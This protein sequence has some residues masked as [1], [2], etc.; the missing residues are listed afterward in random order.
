MPKVVCIQPTH[1]ESDS[2]R[3]FDSSFD[4]TFARNPSEAVELLRQDDFDGLYVA[5]SPDAI[6]SLQS[7]IEN[8]LIL[9]MMPDGVALLDNENKIIRANKRLASWFNKDLVGLNFYQ[10]IGNPMI[11]GPEPSPLSTAAVKRTQCKATILVDDTYYRLLVA[12]ILDDQQKCKQL[13]VSVVDCTES[14][15]QRHKLEALHQA[16]TATRG[17]ATR[18]NLSDGC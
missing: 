9:D 5:D 10:A 2:L 17:F 3:E 8:S 12:P 6:L 4:V 7:L 18:R 14:V 15:G 11:V 13:I 1:G 16:G